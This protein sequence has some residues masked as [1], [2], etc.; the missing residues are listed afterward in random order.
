MNFLH[1]RRSTA[2]YIC[3]AETRV[4]RLK[5]PSSLISPHP[6]CQD[7]NVKGYL[8]PDAE[9]KYK[10]AFALFLQHCVRINLNN[11]IFTCTS[12]NSIISSLNMNDHIP[13]SSC[14]HQHNVCATTTKTKCSLTQF[15]TEIL[16]WSHERFYCR[17]LSSRSVYHQ[18]ER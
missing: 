10:C 11:T 6:A 15:K 4:R 5:D 17:G 7:I 18:N 12:Q 1:M 9:S 3:P 2:A 13:T 16:M 8:G 14:A